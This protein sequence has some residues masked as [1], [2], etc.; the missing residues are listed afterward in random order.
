VLEKPLQRAASVIGETGHNPS[1][2]ESLTGVIIPVSPKLV[3]RLKEDDCPVKSKR[4]DSR[5]VVS[6][7]LNSEVS[8]PLERNSEENE[9]HRKSTKTFLTQGIVFTT[10]EGTEILDLS[11]IMRNNAVECISG[12]IDLRIQG[13]G[14]ELLLTLIPSKNGYT[15]QGTLETVEREPEE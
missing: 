10:Y 15:A 14:W 8:T 2:S 11:K 13:E 9:M 4:P 5:D 12:P 6:W 3:G 1:E 7:W